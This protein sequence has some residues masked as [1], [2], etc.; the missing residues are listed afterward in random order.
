M[1][2]K[3][4][5][6]LNL[7]PSYDNVRLNWSTCTSASAPFGSQP[8]TRCR[9]PLVVPMAAGMKPCSHTSAKVMPATTTDLPTTH[10]I[11]AGA[12]GPSSNH[13]VTTCDKRQLE[14]DLANRQV[15][16]RNPWL[17]QHFPTQAFDSKAI[18]ATIRIQSGD[19][20]H[21]LES[22]LSSVGSRSKVSAED[23]KTQLAGEVVR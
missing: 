5:D 3:N 2:T 14:I 19:D 23:E 12:E 17:G 4:T 1:K 21:G 22:L 16:I 15:G 11:A 7:T 8:S 20:S 18:F 9:T 10:K 13:P 6:V